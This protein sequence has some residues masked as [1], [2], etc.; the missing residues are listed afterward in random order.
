LKYYEVYTVVTPW[1]DFNIDILFSKEA[2]VM[3]MAE[4]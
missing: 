2:S 1:L 4:L 3:Q